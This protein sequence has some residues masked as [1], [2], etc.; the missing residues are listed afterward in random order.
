[1]CNIIS[2]IICK[3]FFSSP[4]LLI[5]LFF[6]DILSFSFVMLFNGL[7][8]SYSS[9]LVPKLLSVGLLYICFNCIFVFQEDLFQMPGLHTEI[10]S[11]RDALDTG[12]PEQLRIL[13]S[14]RFT[15]DN[16]V[17]YFLILLELQFNF[18]YHHRNFIC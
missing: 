4:F 12:V 7:S 11:I 6:I 18:F 17:K 10:Q 3:L 5:F 13:D 9:F 16:I 14:N 1:M 15:Y 2:D 8:V